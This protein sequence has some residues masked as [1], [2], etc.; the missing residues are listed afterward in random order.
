M[1]MTD[2]EIIQRARLAMAE[3]WPEYRGSILAGDWDRDYSAAT[4]ARALRNLD[5]PLP[6]DPDEEELREISE[7][8]GGHAGPITFKVRALPI[9]KAIKAEWGER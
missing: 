9:Y 3:E 2:E 4:V 7:A 1:P 6:V 5:K 8:L